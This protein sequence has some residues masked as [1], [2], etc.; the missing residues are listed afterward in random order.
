MVTH[1]GSCDSKGLVWKCFFFFYG[2][3]DVSNYNSIMLGLPCI[4]K[5]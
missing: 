2:V 5:W 1:V 4:L 3:A